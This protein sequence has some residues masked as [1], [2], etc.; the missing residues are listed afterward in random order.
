MTGSS[1]AKRW[2]L[3]KDAV[4]NAVADAL[5]RRRANKS[6]QESADALPTAWRTRSITVQSWPKTHFAAVIASL[7]ARVA[8]SQANPLSLQKAD[9]AVGR[10]SAASVWNIFYARARG[11][12]SVNR[13]KAS[14][15]VNGLYDQRKTLSRGWTDN[16]NGRRVDEIVGWMEELAATSP[17]QARAALDAFLFEVPDAEVAS[18][19]AFEFGDD[20]VPTE[21]LPFIEGFLARDA[22]LGRRAQAFVAA[23]LAMVH[24][25]E[26]VYTP[27]SIHDPSRRVPGDAS[28]TGGSFQL[29][30]E[31][32][33]QTIGPADLREFSE[34]VAE[35]TD[36]GTA[37]YGALVN[38]DSGKPL[39]TS[40]RHVTEVTGTL[41]SIYDDPATL[42]RDA[43]VWS[44]LP[45]GP[46]VVKFFGIYRHFLQR[47][48]VRPSSIVEWD[49]CAESL[50]I[51]VLTGDD[52]EGEL[53]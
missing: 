11:E 28:L 50:N 1:R 14:P 23:C 6:S 30:A 40:W 20:L 41:T 45:F 2:R 25:V 42:F 4:D 46:A 51:V 48:E 33:W 53:A 49:Q 37:L 39:A 8:D 27:V 35:K 34:T 36:G 18:E 38:A 12:I 31:S 7:V 44:G 15:F 47:L 19:A 10:Y 17:E 52:A 5:R 43:I 3:D 21:V 24:G 9:G 16:D 13:L 22:E 29:A 26:A 32:K